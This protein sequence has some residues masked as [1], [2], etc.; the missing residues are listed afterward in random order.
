MTYIYNNATMQRNREAPRSYPGNYST[1]LIASKGLD[2]LDEAAAAPEP[3]F[4]AIMPIGPHTQTI[5][6]ATANDLPIFEPPVPAERHKDL[7]P[8]V[9]IPRTGNF[10]PDVVRTRPESPG[11]AFI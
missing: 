6:P 2:F 11:F 5:F 1:D 10:N 7:F 3:F 9:T 8:N 4:L